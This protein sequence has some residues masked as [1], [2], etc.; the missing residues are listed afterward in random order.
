[1]GLGRASTYWVLYGIGRVFQ[2]LGRLFFYAGAGTLTSDDLRRAAVLRWR[3]FAALPSETDTVLMDWEERFYKRFL[4]SS[5]RIFLV[6]CGSGR[7]LIVL[8]ER[9]YTVDGIDPVPDCVATAGQRLRARGLRATLATTFVEDATLDGTYDVV[10]FSWCSYCY[11][12]TSAARVRALARLRQHLAPG[13]RVLVSYMPAGYPPRPLLIGIAR[14]V[15]RLARSDWRAEHGDAVVLTGPTSHT[16]Q[17]EHY[18]LSGEVEREFRDAGLAVV[19]H[20]HP[21]P[22]PALLTAQR[23][24]EGATIS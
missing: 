8:L 12:P 16:A 11:I 18:F 14:F 1:M 20:E 10:I 7:D 13:G 3:E 22:G 15:G 2:R 9:G 23:P 24:E 17:F 6:G 19:Y 21:S 4:R 5:D